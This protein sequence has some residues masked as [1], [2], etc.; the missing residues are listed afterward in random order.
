M[1]KNNGVEQENNI[2]DEEQ[3]SNMSKPS[4]VG[5]SIIVP[6]LVGIFIIVLLVVSVI[7]TID[8]LAVAIS[9][10]PD[11][12]TVNVIPN[13]ITIYQQHTLN[14]NKT[15]N[16]DTEVQITLYQLSSGEEIKESYYISKGNW[17]INTYIPL[18]KGDSVTVNIPLY[19]FK[20][21]I[22]IV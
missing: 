20:K 14:I 2:N 12:N 1:D 15:T 4:F 18:S 21:V 11:Q 7:P 8:T 6:F 9:I 16:G 5:I 3:K 22:P 19:N 10:P 17:I 13:K